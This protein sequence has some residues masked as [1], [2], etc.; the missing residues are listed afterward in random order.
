MLGARSD[1]VGAHPGLQV[2]P[3]R[4]LAKE[5]HFQPGRIGVIEVVRIG[6][7]RDD[8]GG[9]VV[10]NTLGFPTV[11]LR[12]DVIDP[13]RCESHRFGNKTVFAAILGS[14]ASQTPQGR[15]D[16]RLAHGPVSLSL[17]VALTLAR[18]TRCSRYW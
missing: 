15:W 5:A 1:Q 9:K 2:T 11:F 16:I 14:F 6:R 4:N 8:Q 3:S 18:R 17:R 7:R 12:N 13:V 10:G